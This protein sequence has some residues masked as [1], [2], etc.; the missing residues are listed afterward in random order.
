MRLSVLLM[1]CSA[2]AGRRWVRNSMDS[3]SRNHTSGMNAVV[4]TAP[5]TNT[6][7][8]SKL[9]SSSDAIDP[10]TITP[11]GYP[12]AMM[13]THRLRCLR[14]A[15]SAAMALMAASMPPMPMPVPK[16]YRLSVV[17]PWAVDA[18]YMPAAMI[19]RHSRIVGRRPKRSAMGPMT[20]EPAAMPI[21]SIDSTMPSRP[22]SMPHSAAMPGEAKLMDSTSKPSSA[23]S[24]TQIAT[25]LT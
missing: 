2:S 19:T 12:V 18:R 1:R 22:R 3:G 23:L 4:M 7:R 10:P 20:I 8:Q 17:T 6:D 5:N 13:M 25:A 11:M 24:A 21:S 9:V 15:Y 16:R 14:L